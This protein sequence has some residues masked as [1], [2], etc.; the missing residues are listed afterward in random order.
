LVGA[1]FIFVYFNA[2]YLRHGDSHKTLTIP[3][4]NNIS[5]V[6]DYLPRNIAPKIL[7]RPKILSFFKVNVYFVFFLAVEFFCHIITL[8][9]FIYF[10]KLR[11]I[12]KL[13]ENFKSNPQ[14]FPVVAVIKPRFS[15]G[16]SLY[17]GISFHNITI[18]APIVDINLIFFHI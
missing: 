10:V 16:F 11:H 3:K 17:V 7:P 18:A 14:L 12:S 5:V 4:I 15:Q 9:L 1:I 2:A 8:L 13:I 6:I